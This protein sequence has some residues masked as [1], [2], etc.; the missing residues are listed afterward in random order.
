MNYVPD[1]A[2]M[3]AAR[4]AAGEGKLTEAEITAAFQDVADYRDRLVAEGKTTGMAE[5]LRRYAEGKAE[6]TRIA[7]AMQRRHASISAIIRDKLSE[8]VDNMLDAGIHPK[9]A[10][11]AVLE[12]T[13]IAVKNGRKS[14]AATRQAYEARY[15][16]SLLAALDRDVPHAVALLRDAKLDADIMREM[17]QLGPDGKPGITKN[18]DAQKVAKIFS[19]H[20]ELSRGDLNKLGASIGKLVGWAGPQTHDDL[21]MIQA[22]KDAWI[23]SI[24]TKLDLERTF[25]EGYEPGQ[26]ADMLG[27]IYDT[28]ITGFPNKANPAS[29]GQRVNPA[30]LAKSLGASRVLHFKGPE[31]ALAYRE[32]FG[33]GN[34]VTGM[35]GHLR[36]SAQVAANME[37]L[38]P[39]PQ[40]MFDG[41]ADTLKRRIKAD[42]KL[43][44]TQKA[45][46]IASL[47]T[48]ASGLRTAMDIASGLS[49]RPEN[50]TFAKIGADIRAVASMSKLGGAV[51]TSIPSDTISVAA[52]ASFRGNNVL[53]ATFNQLAGIMEGRPKGEKAQISYLLGEGFDSILG[54]ISNPQAANDG[55]VGVMASWQQSFFKWN[56]LAWWTDVSR[57]V[58]GRTVAAELGSHATKAWG[59]VPERYRELLGRH[60]ITE[61]HW[62][63]IRQSKMRNANGRDYITPDRVA[64]L[65][66]SAIEPLVQKR[67]DAARKASKVDEAKTATQ[68]AERQADFDARKA[69]IMEDG[70]RDL[71]LSVLRFVADETSYGVVE[72]DAKTQRYM[73]LNKTLRPGSPSGEVIKFIGQFK[74]FP[75]AFTERVLG[76]AIIGQRKGAGIVEQGAHIGTLLAG[77]TIAGYMAMVAKDMIKGNWPPRDPAD[78]RTWLAAFQQGGAAGIYSD[79]LF[80]K[81]NRFGGGLA[82]TAIGPTIGTGFDLAD[83]AMDVRDS[84]M[85]GGEDTFGTAKAFSTGVQM[86]PFGNIYFVKPALDYLILTSLREALSPGY[87]RKQDKSR[88]TEYKQ[89][90]ME[91]FGA[92]RDPMDLTSAF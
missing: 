3:A 51:I 60:G 80:S 58:A 24:V 32:Q 14:V 82:E 27:D 40:I 88:M 53:T 48:Q 72:T 76:R 57:S 89:T 71:Q 73:M 17:M 35:I 26:V 81:T 91:P 65:P 75:V 9:K 2:C 68:Q 11:L 77:M 19:D 7:A 86:V 20:A 47:D 34:T 79:F 78:W 31:E 84:A 69:S 25:S 90:R 46:Q 45:K 87:L 67:I 61:T 83:I 63:A 66:D 42:T 23:G 18:S 5:R 13:Q 10:M 62:D 92:P 74:S 56:G 36:K 12:G 54:Y 15:L 28:I 16:G 30:N 29:K 85:S 38:G 49:S 52:A 6:R 33:F 21:K 4:A 41:L 1:A 44:D 70:R 37:V 50:V 59:K 43:T 22:G 55:P 64:A 8:H 39:N